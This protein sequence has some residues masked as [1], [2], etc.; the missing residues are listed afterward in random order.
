VGT[1]ASK[2]PTIMPIILKSRREIEAIRRAGAL[3]VDIIEKMRRRVCPGITTAALDE[4]VRIELYKA[5]AISSVKFGSNPGYPGQCCISTNDEVLHAPPGPRVLQEG[6]IVTLDVGVSLEGFCAGR[7]L[8][9]PVGMVDEERVRL[10]RV[11]EQTLAA[12][13]SQMM[14]GRRWSDIALLIQQNIQRNGYSVVREFV[15][16]GVGRDWIEEPAMPNFYDKITLQRDFLLR[17]G[18][19]LKVDPIVLSGRPE[20]ELMADGFTIVTRDGKPAAH[21]RHTIA[22]LETGAEVLTSSV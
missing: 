14:P 2:L 11:T 3:A 6:D 22:M 4:L 5:G 13:I 12:A 18:M 20:I 9:V 15:G 19:T 7:A 17:P 16:C 21:A 1:A 10:L 8:T